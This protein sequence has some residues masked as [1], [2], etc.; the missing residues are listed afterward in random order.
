MKHGLLISMVLLLSSSPATA[1]TAT[2]GQLGEILSVA[3]AY[4][5]TDLADG[6]VALDPR[7]A[8]L[9]TIDEAGNVQKHGRGAEQVR[10]PGILQVLERSAGVN[11]GA[12][13]FAIQRRLSLLIGG[14]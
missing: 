1:Q 7:A 10:D 11:A 9:L 12:S 14:L 5:K 2:E 6:A 8:H 13:R 3:L 4:I